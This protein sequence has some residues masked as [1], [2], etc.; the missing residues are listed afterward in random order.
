LFTDTGRA[1]FTAAHNAIDCAA[2]VAN[3]HAQVS[4][5]EVYADPHGASETPGPA[6]R[7]VVDGCHLTWS[8][9]SGS[10]RPG[11]QIG[12]L[13]LEHPPGHVGY[14]IAGYQSC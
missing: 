10:N 4:N 3:V 7:T 14:L 6:G 8:T 2:A 1:E 11:P 12:R 13:E 9:W 5:P